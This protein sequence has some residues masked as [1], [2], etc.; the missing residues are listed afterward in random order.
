MRRSV[1]LSA[2]LCILLLCACASPAGGVSAP[3]AISSSP[4]EVSVS[5]Q[6]VSLPAQDTSAP[7]PD[8]SETPDAP[9]PAPSPAPAPA[10][11]AEQA[12]AAQPTCTLSVSCKVLLNNMDK[13]DPEKVELVPSD[14]WL[15][16]PVAVPFEEGESVFD[17]LLRVCR[18]KKLH[19]EF[20]DTPVYGSAYIEGIGN[21]YEFDAGALSGWRYNVN[22]WYPNY[23]C[24]RYLLADGDAVEW[25]YALSPEGDMP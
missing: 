23:G 16:A 10:K 18:E 25:V 5:A 17:V 13:L 7:A 2:L 4:A 19:M 22:G 6:D 14:G 8:V 1:F 24:S 9:A 15:L 12:E 20:T 21:L 3:A 11:P